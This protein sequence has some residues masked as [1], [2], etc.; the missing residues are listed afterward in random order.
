MQVIRKII[1]G[2]F[3]LTIVF[4]MMGSKDEKDVVWADETGEISVSESG[5][6]TEI[7]QRRNWKYSVA[8]Y[9]TA[10]L[11]GYLGK[12]KVTATDRKSVV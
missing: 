12:E 9:G 4:A 1:A 7:K 6:E 8:E 10:V 3:S 2:V 5:T 11:R